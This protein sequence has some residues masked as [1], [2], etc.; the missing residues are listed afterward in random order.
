[1]KVNTFEIGSFILDELEFHTFSLEKP[2]CFYSVITAVV[3][4]HI[5]II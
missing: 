3:E 2:F 5:N 1:M 4:E